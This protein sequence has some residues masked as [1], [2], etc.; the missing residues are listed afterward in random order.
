MPPSQSKINSKPLDD[1]PKSTGTTR[2]NRHYRP[3]RRN[4]IP[5]TSPNAQKD[6]LPGQLVP[7]ANIPR[8]SADITDATTL[9]RLFPNVLQN[10]S[11]AEIENWVETCKE[12]GLK[13]YN[14]E[15]PPR[16]PDRGGRMRN[17]TKAGVSTGGPTNK[18]HPSAMQHMPTAEYRQNFNGRDDFQDTDNDDDNF[19]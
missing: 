5:T 18:Q 6:G 9:L 3:H 15:E 10:K 19:L 12:S 4:Y 7:R 11:T 8:T 2:S 1:N 14:Q 13:A 16:M 17:E